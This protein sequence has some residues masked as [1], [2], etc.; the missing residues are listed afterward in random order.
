VLALFAILTSK[1][2]DS[3]IGEQKFEQVS[4]S[5]DGL[6]FSAIACGLEE[7]IGKPLV[8]CLHGFPDSARTYRHLLPALADG[9]YRVI[10]PTLRGYEPSSQPD[11]KDYSLP[12]LGSDVIAWIDHFGEE[13]VHLI[14]HDW[15]GA[16][17]FVAGALAP[18]RFLS[19]TAIAGPH[20]ARAANIVGNV[21]RQLLLSWYMMFFQ[22]PGISNAAVKKSD[23]SLLGKLWSNWSPEY[24]LPEPEWEHLAQQF[25]QPGVVSAALSYYRQ[26][27][28]P[29]V[30]FGWRQ[31]LSHLKL[32]PVR[33]LSIIGLDDGCFDS[34][35]FDHLY[36]SQDFP[37]GIRLERIAGVGH[38]P[39]L[40]KPSEINSLLLSWIANET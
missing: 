12:T 8:I 4:L 14:G 30:F 10:A 17:T 36:P 18:E 35:I 13:Q 34:R 7:N 26:N 1:L 23:W 31:N 16:I 19:V 21:P 20:I 24:E 2:E 40:E 37:N 28:S 39:H 27:A 15:G 38:F 3:A 32:V 11:N 9:G 6:R 5:H 33:S 25:D 29:G 22:L